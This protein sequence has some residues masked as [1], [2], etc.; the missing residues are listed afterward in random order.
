MFSP[1]GRSKLNAYHRMRARYYQIR[2]YLVVRPL[3]TITAGMSLLCPGVNPHYKESPSQIYRLFIHA[4]S[5]EL[6][7]DGT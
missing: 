1:P 5:I 7:L 3:E 4:N 6:S 2:G